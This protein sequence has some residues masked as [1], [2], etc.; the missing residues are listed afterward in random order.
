MR[1]NCSIESEN[2]VYILQQII[3]R[4]VK[5]VLKIETETKMFL[6][7]ICKTPTKETDNM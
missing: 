2:K 1:F 3:P 7:F 6:L 5:K 4:V